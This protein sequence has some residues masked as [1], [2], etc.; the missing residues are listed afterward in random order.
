MEAH[1]QPL[2]WFGANTLTE[3]DPEAPARFVARAESTLPLP[4]GVTA[5]FV[6]AHAP[7]PPPPPP[8]KRLRRQLTLE[9]Q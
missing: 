1:A 7:A 3:Y 5:F 8:P 6:Q 9:V 2:V 4:S